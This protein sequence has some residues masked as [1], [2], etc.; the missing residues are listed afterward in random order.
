M[1]KGKKYSLI[2][3]SISFSLLFISCFLVYVVDPYFHYR[4]PNLDLKYNLCDQ[5]YQNDGILR[6][7]DYDALIIGTSMT[8]CFKTSEFN[9]LF[10]VNSVK[11]PFSGGSYK[12][13]NDNIN[14]AINYNQKLKCI[15]RSIDC[16]FY[17]TEKDAMR[18]DAKFYPDYLTDEYYYNDI[19]YLL[20]KSIIFNLTLSKIE[21]HDSKLKIQTFDEAYNWSNK[22]SYGLD[23]IMQSYSRI[24]NPHTENKLTD[25]E[26]KMF[27]D[28]IEQ[29][30]VSTVKANPQIDFYY[31]LTP[32]SIC[33]WD[34]ISRQGD[35]TKHLYGEKMIVEEL[36]KYENVHLFSFN[37]DFPLITNVNNYKDRLHYS[38]EINSYILRNM[39][40]NKYRITK[41]NYQ[42]YLNDIKTF[43]STYDYDSIYK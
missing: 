27:Y 29:N 8:E 30:I 41:D 28:N 17:F 32:Y 34:N 38:G 3:L 1:K 20:N 21:N 42:E 7:F 35:L 40:S 18:Y 22:F 33:Y 15:V 24:E 25:E 10:N 2:M 43:Y 39:A 31:F 16:D 6:N 4:Y 14:R 11:T 26:I 5:R 12:E 37:N 9:Q 19:K 13:I 23:K 36:V